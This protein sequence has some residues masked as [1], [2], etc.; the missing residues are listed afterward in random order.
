MGGVGSVCSRLSDFW[1]LRA[2]ESLRESL[3][4]LKQ[5]LAERP[6]SLMQEVGAGGEVLVAYLRIATSLVLLTL[7]GLH[8]ALGGSASECFIGLTGAIS[9]LLLSQ[10]L[11]KL[12]QRPRQWRWLPFVSAAFDVL[13]VGALLWLL[14]ARDDRAG[15]DSLVAWSGFPLA[16]VAT[17]LRN[18]IRV[19]LMAGI[20]TVL[21]SLALILQQSASPG[22]AAFASHP[23][24]GQLQHL[25]LLLILTL[26][27]AVLVFRTQRLLQLTGNDSLTGLPN[28]SYLT[29]RVPRLIAEARAEGQTLTLAL[30]DLD[31]F[32]RVNEDYGHLVGDRALLHV[33]KTLRLELGRDE[34]M[35][36]VGGE[37]FV[38]ILRHPI[39]AAWERID[40]L[41]Q[42]LE[43]RPF[44]PEADAEP[45]RMTVSAGLASMPQDA[46]H[47]S[48]LMKRADQR[49]RLAK[50][51]GRN[52]VMARDG[53]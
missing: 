25:V 49:L 19:T 44:L 16:I 4:D 41:R 34:P 24:S 7:P 6:D 27:T 48:D 18:D 42:S 2:V 39:G 50:Q 28:R 35:M 52:R 47:L 40:A 22:D 36:R 30:I 5:S 46:N 53:N 45:V 37:E 21:V 43:Q 8:Y 15:L 26:I 32:R 33:V 13:L 29:H 1:W 9:L 3:D 20:L 38:V 31:H 14:G 12:A 11:L 17:A 51:Q 10:L 23:L